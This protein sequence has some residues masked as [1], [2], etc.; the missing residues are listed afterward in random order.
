[1][2]DDDWWWQ[3]EPGEWSRWVC[4]SQVRDWSCEPVGELGWMTDRQITWKTEGELFYITAFVDTTTNNLTKTGRKTRVG[5]MQGLRR[6]KASV[7][8]QPQLRGRV[9]SYLCLNLHREIMQRNRTNAKKHRD[10]GGTF[11]SFLT[12]VILCKN[13][14]YYWHGKGFMEYQSATES[15]GLENFKM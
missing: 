6:W 8:Q 13:R 2:R 5:T 14:L 3:R 9:K 10:N 11:T 1:M 7:R 15:F 12:T 4:V